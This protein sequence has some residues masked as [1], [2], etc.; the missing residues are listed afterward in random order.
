MV[1]P[2]STTT[3]QVLEDMV[4]PALV[5]GGYNAEKP[6]APIGTRLGGGRHFVDLVVQK[7]GTPGF[8][9]SLKWQQSSGT[10]EQKVPF[11]VMCLADAIQRS[12]GQFSNAYL[13]LGGAGWQLR[14]FYTGGGLTPFMR[15]C[16]SVKILALENFLGLAN[17]GKL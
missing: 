13:V 16:E 4:H 10:A 14:D 7:P 17:S 1:P 2:G 15:G 6:K 8:L 11:E 12:Q 5:H 9:V 3:G